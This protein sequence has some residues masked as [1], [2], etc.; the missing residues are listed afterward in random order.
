M[1]KTYMY[2]LD[3]Q[4]KKKELTIVFSDRLLYNL[5]PYD[6]EIKK[7]ILNFF[8][9]YYVFEVDE[10]HFQDAINQVDN[11]TPLK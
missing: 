6:N 3:V 10:K 1:D 2:I 5:V 7:T 9:S 8:E 11:K 4:P